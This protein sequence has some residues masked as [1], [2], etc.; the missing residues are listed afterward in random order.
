MQSIRRTTAIVTYDAAR[1]LLKEGNTYGGFLMLKEAVRASLA[2]ILEDITQQEYSDRTR[3]STLF[4][5]LPE[6]LTEGV[7]LDDFRKVKEIEKKGIEG[8]LNMG[9]EEMESIRKALKQINGVYL[10]EYH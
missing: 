7:T 1:L 5:R 10:G 9:I 4:E 3:L 6:N 2:Y 8:I